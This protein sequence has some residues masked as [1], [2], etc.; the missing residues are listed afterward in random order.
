VPEA[1]GGS[2]TRT[3]LITGVACYT[4]WG[5]LPVLY[6]VSTALGVGAIEMVAHRALWAVLWAGAL[7]LLAKQAPQVG[8]VLRNPRTVA[9][10]TL[11]GVLIGFNWLIFV[12]AIS[13]GRTLEAGF[14]YYI[15]PLLNMAAGAMFFR[16]RID[17]WGALA[18]G[19]AGAGVL[20]QMAAIGEPPW[21]SLSLAVLFCTYGILR[22]RVDA[23]AQTGCSSSAWCSR[24]PASSG[25]CGCRTRARARSGS[26]PR[27]R[28]C[29]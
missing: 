20:I 8:R 29:C 11:T 14:A 18:I 17:R 7:V 3:A 27:S 13:N 21:I 26:P 28:P 22:K 4:I 9:L 15:N 1:Q 23:D 10:L 25:C 19:L 6:L 12:W 24:F 2:E 16:E 5:L